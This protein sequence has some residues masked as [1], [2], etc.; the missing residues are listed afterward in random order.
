[1]SFMRDEPRPDIRV[2]DKMSG[3]GTQHHFLRHSLP[4]DSKGINTLAHFGVSTI[5]EATR[6]VKRMSQRELQQTFRLVRT[7]S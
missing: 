3:S 4:V 1:M 7:F 6:A 5:S 2:G